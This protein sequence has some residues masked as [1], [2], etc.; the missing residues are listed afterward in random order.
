MSYRMNTNEVPGVMA[1][2]CLIKLIYQNEKIFVQLDELVR[3]TH[4]V[5]IQGGGP[6]GPGPPPD[7]RF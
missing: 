2:L 3:I 1:S 5:R 6:G 4:Q 7:P